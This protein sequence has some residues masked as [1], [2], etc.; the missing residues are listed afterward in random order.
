MIEGLERVFTARLRGDRP[1]AADLDPWSAVF[2]AD[3]F[4]G[5]HW[6][7]D[8]RT[9]E[10]ALAIHDADRAHWARFGFG[11]WSVRER[12]TDRYV[13]RI[14]LTHTREVGR[15]AL[16]IGWLLAADARGNGY[17]T[18]MGRETLRV[19]FDVL[20]ADRVVAL[21]TDDNLD[22]LAVAERLGFARTGEIE[23]AG[24]PHQVLEIASE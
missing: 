18:E 14:G 13:G 24:V 16:E 6:P 1:V 4:V 17:A 2:L 12:E 8:H 7:Q 20:E 11:P 5:D 19:A 21:I 9:P 3:D 10:R 23:H 22:S 15:P